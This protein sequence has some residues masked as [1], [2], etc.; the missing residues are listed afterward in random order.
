MIKDEKGASPAPADLE[1]LKRRVIECAEAMETQRHLASMP[2][3][4]GGRLDDERQ[5][6]IQKLDVPPAAYFFR[7]HTD[8][9]LAG[10]PNVRSWQLCEGKPP[11]SL[12]P[13]GEVRPLYTHPPRGPVGESNDSSAREALELIVSLKLYRDNV[14]AYEIA[15]DAYEAHHIARAAL[16]GGKP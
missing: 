10:K 1:A 16:T 2:L 8:D 15:R 14:P 7:F 3:N 13:E 5:N 11:A 12:Y 6:L 4:K 9:S